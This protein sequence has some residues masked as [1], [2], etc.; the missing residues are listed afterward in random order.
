MAFEYKI[1]AKKSIKRQYKNCISNKIQK[2]A[3]KKLISNCITFKVAISFR[4]TGKKFLWDSFF[5]LSLDF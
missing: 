2:K 4:F 1:R 5:V 3:G